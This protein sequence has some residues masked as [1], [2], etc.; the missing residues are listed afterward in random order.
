[1]KKMKRSKEVFPNYQEFQYRDKCVSTLLLIVTLSVLPWLNVD[2]INIIKLVLIVFISLQL[3]PTIFIIFSSRQNKDFAVLLVAIAIFEFVMVVSVLQPNF[4]FSYWFYG[5]YGRNTGFLAWTCISILLFATLL[6]YTRNLENSTLKALALAGRVNVIYGSIQALSLDPIPWQNKNS[7]IIGTLGNPNFFAA[8]VGIYVIVLA[9]KIFSNH[10]SNI[11]RVVLLLE[12]IVAELLI[13]KSESIQGLVVS[14][15]GVMTFVYLKLLKRINSLA[16]VSTLLFGMLG[17]ITLLVGFLGKGPFS[18][19]FQQSSLYRIDYWQAAIRMTL[20]SPIFGVGLNGYENL[21]RQYRTE[22]IAKLVSTATFSD[23]PH[24]VILEMM[25]FGGLLMLLP[26]TLIFIRFL[27]MVLR[28]CRVGGDGLELLSALL[29]GFI[30]QSLISPANLALLTWGTV[31]FGLLWGKMHSQLQE[32]QTP[33][34]SA[35]SKKRSPFSA[36]R[37]LTNIS[38][39]IIA[40]FLASPPQVKDMKYSYAL[41][42]AKKEFLIEATF[43]WPQT[44]FHF[45]NTLNILRLNGL[46]A[47]ALAL[48]KRS[49]VEFPDCFELWESIYINPRANEQE[50]DLA[51]SKVLQLE[52]NYF[53]AKLR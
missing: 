52:P 20:D 15:A 43:S 12:L 17:T 29:I 22:N 19:L 11:A 32:K 4:K 10:V 31:F 1:M 45:Y 33:P 42:E 36:A 51:R 24:N 16:K 46:H 30:V 27:I 28:I 6:G 3:I 18:F 8:F 50:V 38:I 41:K 49:V 34:D 14:F 26:F 7:T 44:C 21:Y 53:L 48:A 25:T 5:T 37:I 35:S 23:S 40:L 9:Y 39:G 2:P 47:D 13:V